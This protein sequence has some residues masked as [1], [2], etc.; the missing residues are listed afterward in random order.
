M[1]TSKVDRE[2]R[3]TR[4]ANKRAKRESVKAAWRKGLAQ[5]AWRKKQEAI[6]RRNAVVA[7]VR[8]QREAFKEMLET[9]G[10]RS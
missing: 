2:A 10:G 7:A 9:K 5:A 6:E 8:E 3:E 1:N 4:E